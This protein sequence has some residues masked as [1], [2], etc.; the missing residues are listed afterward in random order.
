MQISTIVRRLALLF[1]SM[2]FSLGFAI[3]QER[4]VTGTVTADQEG[5]LPGVNVTVQGT[6]TGVMT[7]ANGKYSLKVPGP[8]AVLVFSSI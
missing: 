3:A 8:N 1:L 5:P 7:D 6:T 4:T 2:V